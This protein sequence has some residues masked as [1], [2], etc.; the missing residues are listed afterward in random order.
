MGSLCHTDQHKPGRMGS[1]QHFWEHPYSGRSLAFP[2]AEIC[3][4]GSDPQ[5]VPWLFLLG[6]AVFFTHLKG[7]IHLGKTL[8]VLTIRGLFLANLAVV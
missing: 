8:Q 2:A 5:A 1:W 3:S 6:E 7:I 4:A